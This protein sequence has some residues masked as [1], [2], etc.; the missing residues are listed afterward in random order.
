MTWEEKR[1]IALEVFKGCD[2][3]FTKHMKTIKTMFEESKCMQRT[4]EKYMKEMAIIQQ[5]FRD[6]QLRNV[7]L[8]EH[9]DDQVDSIFEMKIHIEFLKKDILSTKRRQLDYMNK[10]F[11][12]YMSRDREIEE[13]QMKL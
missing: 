9:S 13:M 3:L 8:L 2:P 4:R 10:L 5:Q 1:L 11:V 7:Y 12:L 6:M